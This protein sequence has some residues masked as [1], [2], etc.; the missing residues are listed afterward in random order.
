MNLTLVFTVDCTTE[1]VIRR[2][3]SVEVDSGTQAGI[4]VP[5]GDLCNMLTVSLGPS[6]APYQPCS[7]AEVEF[8]EGRG[9]GSILHMQRR[10]PS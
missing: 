9:V 2:T 7:T 3:A 10:Y 8:H 4:Q 5:E 6:M 1:H